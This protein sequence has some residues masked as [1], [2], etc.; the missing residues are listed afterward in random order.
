MDRGSRVTR[1]DV[2]RVAGTSTAVVSYVI[3]SGPRPVSDSTKRRVLEAI[4]QTGYRPNSIARALAHGST[5]TLGFVVP[6]ISNP[7]FAALAHA[8]EDEAFSHGLVLLLGDAAESSDREREIV[9]N[10]IARQVDG[11]VYIGVETHATITGAVELGLPVVI[12]DRVTDEQRAAS[13]VIDNVLAAEAATQHLIDHG[14]K[15][16]RMV[17]GPSHLSTSHQRRRG[18]ANA[19]TASGMDVV[20]EVTESPFTREGG[21]ES[22]RHLLSLP[23]RPDALFVA[24]E[25]Q[26]IGVLCAAAELGITVPAELAIV[27]FDG[28]PG[29]KYCVPP[30]TTVSQ[31]F[32]E[33]AKHAI[34]LLRTPELYESNRITC[35]FELT[36]RSSCGCAYPASTVIQSTDPESQSGD[37]AITYERKN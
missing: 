3:N 6:N 9:E 26:A 11:L 25:E 28:T 10:F 32:V 37:P 23:L 16:I 19:L 21:Y 24:S 8:L 1:A 35:Q 33:I 5:R 29:S 7:F 2:A 27:S 13:V 14:Y 20:D 4:R 22:A 31:P 15:R 36:V 18:W 34:S 12:L 17:S 30:L